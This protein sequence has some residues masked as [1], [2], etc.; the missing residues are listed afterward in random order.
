MIERIFDVTLTLATCNLAFRKSS[1][2]LGSNSKGNFLSI[3]E[4]LS[5]YDPILQ[6]LLLR[7]QGTTKYLSPKIQNDLI[8]LLASHVQKDIIS[9]LQ[10][11]PFF[12]VI[13]DTTQD[14]SKVDQLSKVYRYVKI[15]ND[16]FGKP[17]ELNI[18]ETFSSFIEVRNQT[19]EG[20]ADEIFLTLES[21]GLNLSKC[22][23]QGYD[24]ASVMSGAYNDVQKRI[25]EKAP[26][27]SFV[28]CAAHNLNLVL[29]DAVEGT[30]DVCHFFETV[31]NVYCF[32][33]HS[34]V[35]WD[36]L[37]SSYQSG[38][39]KVS[40][41][42]LNPTRWAGRFDAINALNSVKF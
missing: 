11:A 24:G 4:L 35:R 14:V 41:K 18:C 10:S 37:K 16:E 12:S 25:K 21:K 5:K 31:Q 6:E 30:R 3:I 23:G 8:D 9:E 40:L 38:S 28:H 15:E 7:P 26:H 17:R 33:G 13:F 34:I 27:A 20:L 19:A 39:S 42:P 29:K 36:V 22:R 1:E 2:K 32:F